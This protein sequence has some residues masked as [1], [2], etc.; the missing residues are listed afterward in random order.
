MILAFLNDE[1]NIL[2][3]ILII[4]KMNYETSQTLVIVLACLIIIGF[5][6]WMFAQQWHNSTKGFLKKFGINLSSD[7]EDDE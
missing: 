5:V 4:I 6:V 3:F 1:Y 2:K 7:E